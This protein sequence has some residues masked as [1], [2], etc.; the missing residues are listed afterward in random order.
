MESSM[1]QYRDSLYEY[2]KRRVEEGKD[3]NSNI[4]EKSGFEFLSERE[5]L[6][7]K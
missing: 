5:V 2:K 7:D 4:E 1:S 3:E 6:V